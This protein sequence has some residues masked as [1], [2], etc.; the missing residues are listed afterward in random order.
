MDTPNQ[1]TPS[2]V[3][4]A[5]PEYRSPLPSAPPHLGHALASEWTKF[6]SLRSTLWTLASMVVIV[7]AVGLTTAF[8]T[9]AQDYSKVPYTAPAL[10]G[11]M[12]GQLCI[13]TLG[14]LVITSEYGT[15]LVRTTF[16]AA[17]RRSRV[18]TAK[19]LVFSS[20]AFTLCLVTV[21]FV[22]LATQLI[23][24]NAPGSHRAGDWMLS[25]LGG[26][27][28]VTLLGVLG[29]ALGTML[30]HSAGTLTTM[31]GVLL[32]PFMMSAMLMPWT[33]TQPIGEAIFRFSP[34]VALSLL[35]GMPVSGSGSGLGQL[36]L[37]VV[38]CGA[39]VTASYVV[40]RRRD[41]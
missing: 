20:A 5:G 4:P 35:F 23:V 8:Q 1:P 9:S 41:V 24:P 26:S 33:A 2:P 6:T 27:L 19:Y 3:A 36:L 10:V 12:L 34:P 31:M 22:T 18:L 32:G 30:R 21:T 25:A 29:L 40:L 38:L 17:P 7:V 39:A 37:L 14:V 11:M 15:G 13:V 16:T 28:Y